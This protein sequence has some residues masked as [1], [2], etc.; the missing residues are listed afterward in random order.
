MLIMSI[1]P[2]ESKPPSRNLFQRL[3]SNFFLGFLVTALS[4]FTAATNYATYQISNEASDHDKEGSRLLANSNT[5]YVLATQYILQDYTMYDGFYVQTG[6]D[7]FAAEYYQSNF[8]PEL[9][10][11]YDR[12][13]AFDD[14][15]YD[16][17]YAYS[18]DL[19]AQAFD[20]FDA[21]T[22]A[23]EREAGFQLAMLVSAVGLAFAAYASL[24]DELN[25]MRPMFALMSLLLLIFSV[26]QAMGA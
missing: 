3:G 12:D 6:V 15:Y 14:Q 24:L 22:A 18:D 26:I 5:E 10:A 11:S 21:A 8:S 19:F 4:V 9:Q 7:D 25:K 23:S 17:M 16:E 2:P 1:A 20:E 13:D